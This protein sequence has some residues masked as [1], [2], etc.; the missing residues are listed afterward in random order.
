[1]VLTQ[2]VSSSSIQQQYSDTARRLSS[3]VS[4]VEPSSPPFRVEEPDLT[5]SFAG[6]SRSIECDDSDLDGSPRKRAW[7]K[8]TVQM[9]SSVMEC[10]LGTIRA[11]SNTQLRISAEK[12]EI[13]F[14]N[15]Q[16]QGE[17][18]TSY[19]V[20]PAG[21]LIRLGI[22]Y[23]LHLKFLSSSTQ[24]WKP[25]LKPFCPVPD[26]ALIFEFCK[27]G[28]TDA[29]RVLLSSGDASVRDT[30]SRGYT[31][32]HVSLLRH[33]P[34]FFVKVSNTCFK[35]A[36]QT[37]RP[38]LC[39]MLKS[40]GADINALTYRGPTS[41]AMLAL[42][43]PQETIMTDMVARTPMLLASDSRHVTYAMLSDVFD[44]LRLL[45]D[46]MDFLDADADANG[47]RV[48]SY[49]CGYVVCIGGES[50]AKSALLLWMLKLLTYELKAY[51]IRSQIAHLLDWI[52]PYPGLEQASNLLL[53]LGGAN[54]ID[55]A[56]N[57]TDGY[58]ILHECLAYAEGPE[59]VSIVLA[60][61]PNLH[62]LGFHEWYTP[63]KESPM[64]LAMYS[65][66]AFADWL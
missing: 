14:Y 48:L 24:G 54:I 2:C 15:E 37:Y 8:R 30:D 39:E 7:F 23:G 51:Y 58:T 16:D 22:R 27:Q 42:S 44:T 45:T 35:F 38:E 28:N 19:T 47:W 4:D 49:L 41:R 43:H 46:S 25:T 6:N 55:V 9:A 60:K 3:F 56:L 66:W 33:E 61:G 32:L 65:S 52:L 64:S 1:M 12:D 40:A 59:D 31:P 13:M 62:L 21:W 57:A 26:D 10:S 29:V 11:E 63:E 5:K 34:W 53:K 20:Y 36:A 18:E 50:E 17:H